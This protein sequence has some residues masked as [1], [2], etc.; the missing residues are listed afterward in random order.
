M[1][2]IIFFLMFISLFRLGYAQ[3]MYVKNKTGN[4]TTI[5]LNSLRYLS[6]NSGQLIV[7][8]KSGN[9][10]S[11]ILSEIQKMT[12]TPITSLANTTD[13]NFE[14]RLFPNPVGDLLSVE[15]PELKSNTVQIELLSLE[16]RVLYTKSG[17]SQSVFTLNISTLK[18]GLYLC[19]I[20]NGD[21]VYTQKFIKK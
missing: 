15:L 19:R 13:G 12:F 21:K 17:N 10:Q 1:K 20:Y 8:P 4:V 11:I 7:T 9:V 18:Q 3:S 2:K 16:G 14:V 6:F 5:V